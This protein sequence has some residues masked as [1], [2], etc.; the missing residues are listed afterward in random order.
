MPPLST[1][2]VLSVLY[3]RIL[4]SSVRRYRRLMLMSFTRCAGNSLLFSRTTRPAVP[5][6]V[7]QLT[8]QIMLVLLMLLCGVEVRVVL[9]GGVLWGSP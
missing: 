9:C 1:Y 4:Q 8:L 5:P 6:P 2:P 7:L 3:Y